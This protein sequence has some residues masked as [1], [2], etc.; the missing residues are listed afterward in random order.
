MQ[1]CSLQTELYRSYIFT[2]EYSIQCVACTYIRDNT[3]SK[4]YDVVNYWLFIKSTYNFSRGLHQMHRVPSSDAELSFYVGLRLRGLSLS[5][6][7]SWT[8]VIVTVYWVNGADRQVL[9][10]L[11][12]NNSILL[13]SYLNLISVIGLAFSKTEHNITQT[14]FKLLVYAQSSWTIII[15]HCNKYIKIQKQRIG[16]RR[17]LKDLKNRL[18]PRSWG[19]G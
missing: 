3:N 12:N 7:D 6:T 8:C 5:D 14:E 2:S 11:R 16:S 9:K 17:Q 15:R 4:A 10:I 13:R 19:L 18:R 1:T